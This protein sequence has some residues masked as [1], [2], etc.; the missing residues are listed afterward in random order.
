MRPKSIV[1]ESKLMKILG[2]IHGHN[3]SACLLDD[4]EVRG[5]VSE[6]RFDRIKNSTAFPIRSV[7]YLLNM[8]NTKCEDIDLIVHASKTVPFIYEREI[9]IYED[10]RNDKVTT[11]RGVIYRSLHSL[12]YH[13]P[14]VRNPIRMLYKASSNA[15]QKGKFSERI[16]NAFLRHLNVDGSKIVFADHHT[17]HAYSVYYGFIPRE[18]RK[19]PFLVMTL[20][21]EGDGL[22]STVH[23]VKDGKWERIAKTEAGNSIASLYGAITK[24]LKMRV[25]EHEYKVMGLAPYCSAYNRDKTLKKLN[26]L[27]WVND[28]L[29]FG[30]IGGGN[31]VIKWLN[32]NLTDDRFDAVAAAAQKYVEDL[33]VEWVTKAIDK[34][35][36][37]NIA[38]SGGFFMNIKAN[39]VIMELPGVQRLYICPSGGDESCPIGALYYGVEQLGLDPN[40]YCDNIKNIYLGNEFSESE[41]ENAIAKNCTGRRFTISRYDDIETE[42]A[43]LLS[44]EKVV[45]RVNGRMEF[46][47]RALGNRSILANPSSPDVVK[48]INEQIKNRD[49]WMP[50]ACSI[51]EERA[52]DYLINP[53]RIEMKYMAVSC[54][55]TPLAKKDLIAA[56]HPYDYTA[57]PQLV[58]PADNNSYYKILKNFEALTGIGGV[59]NTSLNLHGEPLVNSPEDAISTFSRSGLHYLA[60]GNYLISKQ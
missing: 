53:K 4:G 49:F 17:C 35:G 3:S 42:V 58:S 14:I 60:L 44:E 11:L 54:E 32:E 24:F 6:E 39:K 21:G 13:L 16:R 43:K 52:D 46:G 15:W 10:D 40:T 33:A 36:I 51:L 31:F 55:T 34:T 48:V 12:Y 29:S 45:S 20:D 26:G 28:D 50:F 22:C 5:C 30:S 25:N 27:F 9:K 7:N 8:A 38:L 23:V 37:H 18:V 57:R 56:I 1:G 41:I 2:M 59:L 19:E 47:A